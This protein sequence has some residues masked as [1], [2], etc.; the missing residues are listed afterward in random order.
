MNVGDICTLPG[1]TGLW[2]FVGER[3]AEIPPRAM[4]RFLRATHV[5]P[6]N[7]HEAFTGMVA[8]ATLVVAPTFHP[9]ETVAYQGEAASV[10]QDNGDG[11]VTIE[12]ERRPQVGRCPDEHFHQTW[13]VDADK[14]LLVR[15]NIHNFID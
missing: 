6:T 7:P 12:F 11:T 13:H 1:R 9:G 8:S 3:P 5:D 14:P 2:V 15:A 4:G 10:V